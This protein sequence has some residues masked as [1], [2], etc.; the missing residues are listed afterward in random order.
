M[1]QILVF[2]KQYAELVNVFNSLILAISF[3]AVVVQARANQKLVKITL[4]QNLYDRH[5]R[6]STKMIE[7]PSAAISGMREETRSAF[8]KDGIV[9]EAKV[10]QKFMLDLIIDEAEYFF[11]LSLLQ[12]RAH[13][14]RLVKRMMSNQNIIDH[15]RG[16]FRGT[17]RPD[18]ERFV[19]KY[20]AARD[21]K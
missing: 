6:S 15:W 12:D 7:N 4:L 1:A 10:K 11:L 19:E 8:T 17:V 20:Y 13:N 3:L 9:D 14:Q 21:A 18:F 5:Y 16:P 2:A